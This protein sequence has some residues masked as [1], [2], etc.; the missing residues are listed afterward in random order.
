MKT[1]R[2]SPRKRN[3]IDL[4]HVVKRNIK[5]HVQDLSVKKIK[6]RKKSNMRN[7]ITDLIQNKKKDKAKDKKI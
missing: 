3:I 1:C 2:K 4:V 6:R 5:D 7:K